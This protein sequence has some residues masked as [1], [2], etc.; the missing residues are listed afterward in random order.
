MDFSGMKLTDEQQHQLLFMMLVQQHEQIGMVGLGKLKDPS[1]D[2][3]SRDLSAAKYAIDTLQMLERY[4]AGN[5]NHE[6]KSYLSHVLNTLRLNY[7]DEVKADKSTQAAS[8]SAS[9]DV[10]KDAAADAA[11]DQ[12]SE[13]SGEGT[14]NEGPDNQA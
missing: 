1:T 11:T 10:A 8:G 4:T 9:T 2:T 13:D 12:S 7:V 5:V 3:I 14:G 6:M